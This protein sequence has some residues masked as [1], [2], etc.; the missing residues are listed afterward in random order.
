[1]IQ[2]ITVAA[3]LIALFEGPCMFADVI[4]VTDAAVLKGL[5]PYNWV[6]TMERQI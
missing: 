4:P 2:Q 1:M 5:S 6:L 3:A